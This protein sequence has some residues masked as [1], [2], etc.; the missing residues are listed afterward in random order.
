MNFIGKTSAV[1]SPQGKIEGADGKTFMEVV[2]HGD[3][4]ANTPYKVIMGRYGLTTAA[5]ADDATTFFVGVPEAAVDASEVDT[6]LVQIGGP[7]DALVTP[8]LS[9]TAGHSLTINTGVVADGGAAPPR[10]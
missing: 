7:I 8:S 1:K 3:L 6:C 4:V 2:P 5:L 10:S 9:V